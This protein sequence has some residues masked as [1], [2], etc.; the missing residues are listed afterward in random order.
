M[1]RFLSGIFHSLC[2]YFFFSDHIWLLFKTKLIFDFCGMSVRKILHSLESFCKFQ[3]SQDCILLNLS[4]NSSN[5]KISVALPS[6]ANF[7]QEVT[8]LFLEI[9]SKHWDSFSPGKK[10]V[11]GVW[12]E[13]YFRTVEYIFFQNV[14]VSVESYKNSSEVWTD[15]TMWNNFLSGAIYV[16]SIMWYNAP[17]CFPCVCTPSFFCNSSGI[18]NENSKFLLVSLQDQLIWSRRFVPFTFRSSI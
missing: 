13:A 8:N 11:N 6:A 17:I 4:A 1:V 9:S 7:I 12:S 3:Y 15:I 2:F 18:L 16:A 10:R 5:S 14:A